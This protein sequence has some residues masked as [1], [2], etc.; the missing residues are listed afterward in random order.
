MA[1]KIVGINGGA[2]WNRSV[3]PLENGNDRPRKPCS[4]AGSSGSPSMNLLEGRRHRRSTAAT[5]TLTLAEY[6]RVGSRRRA[7]RRPGRDPGRA[8]RTHG[9]A[10]TGLAGGD[11]LVSRTDRGGTACRPGHR[12]PGKSPRCSANGHSLRPRATMCIWLLDSDQLHLFRTTGAAA[13]GS[14]W[15]RGLRGS[16]MLKGIDSRLNAEVL[17]GARAPRAMAPGAWSCADTPFPLGPARPDTG[18][19]RVVAVWTT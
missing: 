14:A 19:G 12:R 6:H 2:I 5:A 15:T 9:P 16:R 13:T 4:V 8:A 10:E 11:P 7:A 3:S 1:D 17:A 18:H